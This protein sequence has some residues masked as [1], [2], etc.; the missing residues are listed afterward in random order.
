MIFRHLIPDVVALRGYGPRKR[1]KVY[2]TNVS[3][4]VLGVC[5]L[6]HQE[7]TPLLY[8]IPTF[9]LRPSVRW[10]ARGSYLGILQQF[11]LKAPRAGIAAITS[12]KFDVHHTDAEAGIYLRDSALAIWSGKWCKVCIGL[13]QL[14]EIKIGCLCLYYSADPDVFSMGHNWPCGVTD[15]SVLKGISIIV[16]PEEVDETPIAMFSGH[17]NVHFVVSESLISIDWD[18]SHPPL[19][20]PITTAKVYSWDFDMSHI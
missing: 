20:L 14:K 7:A 8:G 11:I 5:R 3:T 6:F 13:P 10:K 15:F 4:A 17:H 1:P 16:E 19:C 2:S 12:L 9:H 18:K